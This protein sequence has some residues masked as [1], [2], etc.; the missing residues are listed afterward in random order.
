MKKY[1]YFITGEEWR[2]VYTPTYL[3]LLFIAL[4]DVSVCAAVM[5]GK[6]YE[7]FP[8]YV[9]YY[10][11]AINFI[12]AFALFLIRNSTQPFHTRR[13]YRH[14][15]TIDGDTLHYVISNDNERIE[16]EFAIK[17]IKENSV[18]IKYYKSNFCYVFVPRRVVN[19]GELMDFKFT[20]DD[21]KDEADN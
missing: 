17:K 16:S 9:Q 20:F 6:L 18:G 4:V 7:R 14:D 2:K 1:T 3:L 19:G 11:M 13:M 8:P 15:I 10:L 12:M 21:K 5:I